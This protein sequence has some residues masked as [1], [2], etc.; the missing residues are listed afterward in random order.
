[1]GPELHKP[2]GAQLLELSQMREYDREPN[3][4]SGLFIP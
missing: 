2:I 3:N 4:K 1:M